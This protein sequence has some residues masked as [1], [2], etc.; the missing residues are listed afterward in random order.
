MDNEIENLIKSERGMAL[1][2]IASHQSQSETT[3]ACISDEEMISFISHNVT[4][5]QREK[6]FAHLNSCSKCYNNWLE[7]ASCVKQE[8]PSTPNR[9]WNFQI[10]IWQ[11][12]MT[13]VAA[14]IL[15]VTVIILL[16]SNNSINQN[17][18]LINPLGFNDEN[19]SSASQAFKA[20]IK[21][22]EASS[23]TEYEL[24][25]WFR[26]LKLNATQS[27]T[28]DFWAQQLKLLQKFETNEYS[29]DEDMKTA[30][31]DA[32]TTI[33]PLLLDLQ[34]DPNNIYKAEQLVEKLEF[35]MASI[36]DS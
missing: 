2:G 12:L 28:N 8:S 10:P 6:I 18:E 32:L 24:G 29:S 23:T 36:E 13:S 35:F 5:K 30:I 3:T 7:T 11:P 25:R 15:I 31:M 20:G 22:D 27:V 34:A 16:P 1:L 14:T 26:S 17:D 21:G 19:H 33:K 4:K 9:W